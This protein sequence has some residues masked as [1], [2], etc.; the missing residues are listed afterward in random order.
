[1][2]GRR[3]GLILAT[4]EQL[5]GTAVPSS[6]TVWMNRIL[7]TELQ[8]STLRHSGAPTPRWPTRLTESRTS[9]SA[10]IQG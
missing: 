4:G 10:L 1:M 9:N 5:G 8:P 6:I 2:H 7:A 3:Q